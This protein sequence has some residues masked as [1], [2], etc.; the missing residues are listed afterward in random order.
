MT[1]DG[2]R[3]SLVEYLDQFVRNRSGRQVLRWMGADHRVA[4]LPRAGTAQAIPEVHYALHAVRARVPPRADFW[5]Q[6][7]DL[8]RL[9]I[10]LGFLHDQSRH[11]D[12]TA[13]TQV[14][15]CLVRLVE[16][17]KASW[18]HDLL[19]APRV[20]VVLLDVLRQL[21]LELA[22]LVLELDDIEAIDLFALGG[23]EVFT[24]RAGP[25]AGKTARQCRIAPRF[26]LVF[27]DSTSGTG[28]TDERERIPHSY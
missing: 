8:V 3:T 28:P 9:G 21:R 25:L 4:L 6:L 20:F 24:C 5:N 10:F 1:W 23:V 14:A 17:Y 15:R 27:T 7:G 18:P 12:A 16:A 19:I 13:G 26:P 11:G 22:H 2:V